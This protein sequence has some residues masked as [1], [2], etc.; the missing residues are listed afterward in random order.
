MHRRVTIVSSLAGLAVLV[1]V[2]SLWADNKDKKEAAKGPSLEMIKRLAG[3][4]EALIPESKEGHKGKVTYRVT[5]AGSAVLETAFADTDHEMVTVYYE[6]GGDLVLTHYCALHNQP[7]MRAEP[8]SAPNQI[9][10]KFAGGTNINPEKDMHMHEA[11]FTFVD[12]D[13]VK[14]EWTLF[15]DGKATGSHAIELTRKKKG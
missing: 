11:K 1:V 8:G 14:A 9:S 10:F 4:W 13:H 6:D 15:K 7:R 3:E 2:G 5:S 12:D